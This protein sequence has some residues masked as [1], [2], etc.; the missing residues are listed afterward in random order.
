MNLPFQ[1]TTTSINDFVLKSM[2]HKTATIAK[3]NFQTFVLIGFFERVVKDFEIDETDN[4]YMKN[5]RSSKGGGCSKSRRRR[6]RR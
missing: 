5:V 4:N 6:R 3:K 2:N 1:P